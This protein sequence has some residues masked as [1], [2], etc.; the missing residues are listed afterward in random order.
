MALLLRSTVF[1]ENDQIH[2]T[3]TCDGKNFSP[4]LQWTEPPEGTKSFVLICE[5]PDAPSG[6]FVHW[7][8]FDVPPEVQSFPEGIPAKGTVPMLG[9]QG[10][11]D[12][13]NVGYGG[14]CPPRN[15]PHR[16]HFKLYALDTEL[17]LKPG[18]TTKGEVLKAMDG[19]VLADARLMGRYSRRSR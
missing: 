7:V 4:P 2:P 16:Y 14:P 12:F 1:K 6:T 11:N 17:G 10:Q 3:Y 18:S 8:A 5:D 9:K 13:G 19:H 15:G